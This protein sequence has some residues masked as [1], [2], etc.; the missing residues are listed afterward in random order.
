MKHRIVTLLCAALLALAASTAGLAGPAWPKGPISVLVGWAAGG[1]SDIVSRALALEMEKPLGTKIIVTN[2]TGA[3]GAIAAR[4]VLSAPPDGYTWFGG[5]AVHGTWPLLGAG[6]VSW[7]NFYSWLAV[8]FPTTIYVR[9]D[10]PWRTIEDLLAEIKAKPGKLKYGHPGPGSNGEIFAGVLLATAGLKGQAISIPYSGGREAGKY[11]LGKEIDFISV[12]MGDVTDWAKAGLLRPLANLYTKPMKFEGVEF[13]P[14]TEVFPKLAPLT[15]IN[16]FFGI[17][18]NRKTPDD[19]VVKITEAFIYAVKQ[20]RFRKIA[21]EERAGVLMP[22]FGIESD[23]MMSKI[24]SARSWPLFELGIAPLN[25]SKLG[26]PR[27]E[28]WK[29]PPHAR[30]EFL[31]PWPEQVEVMFRKL[32]APS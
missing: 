21:V 23:K 13:R 2:V 20:E 27:L 17:Y 3:L 26:I 9:A 6:P 29:W 1:A 25:P 5:A 28:E 7:N 22:L 8:M 16:P 19:I 12:T 18:V 11:L 15:A 14:I 30:A 4:Q 10:S 24:E 31:K 32:R